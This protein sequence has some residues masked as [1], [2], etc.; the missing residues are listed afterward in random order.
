M[1]YNSLNMKNFNNIFDHDKRNSAREGDFKR[2]DSGRREFRSR[3]RERPQMYEAV[4]NDCGKRCEVPFRPTGDKPIYC[5]QCFGSHDRNPRPER[6]G[7]ER[8]RFQEKRMFDATCDKCGKRFELPF[9][10][11]GERAVY[12]KECF[13]K[14]GS[15]NTDQRKDQLEA[16]NAKLDMIIKMLTPKEE[17]KKPEKNTIKKNSKKEESKKIINKNMAKGNNSRRKE[18][19]KPKKDKKK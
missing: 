6:G 19:K 8:P 17:E 7:R 12:C 11:T 18:T 16:L 14:G 5:S 2:K 9:K 4:C 15:G 3:D 13:E 1:P 10:P